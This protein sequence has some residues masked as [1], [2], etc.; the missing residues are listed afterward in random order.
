MAKPKVWLVTYMTNAYGTIQYMTTA[1]STRKTGTALLNEITDMGSKFARKYKKDD[2]NA[3]V[4]ALQC[5]GTD[6][7]YHQEVS[8]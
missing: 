5:L 2:D 6:K 7:N 1:I 4:L 3:I 8:E